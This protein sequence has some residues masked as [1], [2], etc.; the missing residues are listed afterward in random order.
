[1]LDKFLRDSLRISHKKPEESMFE[2]LMNIRSIADALL[3]TS[4]TI[5]DEDVIGYDTNELDT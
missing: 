2:F 4:S 1:M 3:A 5:S